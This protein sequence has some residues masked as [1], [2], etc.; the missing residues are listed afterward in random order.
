MDDLG[1]G[2]ADH[3]SIGHALVELATNVVNHAYP[4][5]D[6][7][8][9]GAGLTGDRPLH[10]EAVLERTGEVVAT[11]SDRGEWQAPGTGP[12]RGGAGRGITI[13]SGLV[14]SLRVERSSRG[15]LME[16]RS[17]LGRPVH[18]WHAEQHS[19][20][21]VADTLLDQMS[22]V[23]VTGRLTASGP[24]DEL[25]AELFHAALVDVTHAGTEAATVDLTNVTM[26]ASPGVQSLFDLSAHSARC[27][28]RMDIVAPAQSPARHVLDLVGLT[29][30]S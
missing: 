5:H 27:G 21:R 22:T 2:L 13:A 12:G 14:D 18:L 11:V 4:H 26:L 15:T 17:R 1:A 6:P 8:L 10:L 23:T 16:I 25:S 29:T 30:R 19:S 20:S 28:V 24:V 9:M 3:I 7:L